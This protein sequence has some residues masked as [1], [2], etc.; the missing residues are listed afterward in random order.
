MTRQASRE[1]GHYGRR[2][3]TAVRLHT[4]QIQL[5]V[6]TK[7]P[8]LL[9]QTNNRSS[10][11]YVDRSRHLMPVSG[12]INAQFAH[13]YQVAH[14]SSGN[15]LHDYSARETEIPGIESHRKQLCAYRESHTAIYRLWHRLLYT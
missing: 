11:S 15:T 6:G 12:I 8:K 14:D 4:G 2:Q 13:R 5:S 1:G 10:W 9:V 3:N 7:R